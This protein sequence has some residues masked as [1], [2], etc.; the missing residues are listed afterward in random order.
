M[1]Q[2]LGLCSFTVE[3]MGSIP[4]QGIQF[5]QA[6]GRARKKKEKDFSQVFPPSTCSEVF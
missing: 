4:G 6:D 2:Q 1:V 3:G 5:S